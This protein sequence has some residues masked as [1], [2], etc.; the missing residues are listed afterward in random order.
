M[1]ISS[2][3]F[4]RPLTHALGAGLLSIAVGASVVPVTHADPAQ[5]SEASSATNAA[6]SEK[7]I[8][9]LLNAPIPQD[10]DGLLSH[11]KQIS[12]VAG[13]TNEE[14][15]QISE[16]LK[17]ADK[18]VKAARNAQ[19]SS[20]RKAAA[21]QK[22]LAASR[23]NVADIAQAKY[24]GATI[25]PV[26]AV[27]GAS[28]PQAA[29]ERSSYMNSLQD[30]NIRY[31]DTLD[32]DLQEAASANSDANISKFKADYRVNYLTARQTELDERTTQLDRLSGEIMHIVDGFSPA[33]RKRWVDSN[34]PINVDVKAFLA[35]LEKKADGA[36]TGDNDKAGNYAGA[37]AAA[38]SKIG[39]PYGWG[40][41]GPDV[42]DCSGL[43][44]WAYQQIGVSIPRTSS[45]QIAGGTP[46][47]LDALQP[48]DIIGYYPGITHVGMY[49]GDG[50]VVHA[51]D[52]GIPVQVVP[53]NSMPI[54]G[55]ARY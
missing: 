51:A 29:M 21:A 25:D 28:G 41:A 30:K 27:A 48:G 38:M 39:A 3:R 17:N 9:D 49:I 35:G 52:Y 36:S 44:Y 10:F 55:A 14:V 6:P 11:M 26:S 34:G 8:E 16:E 12:R 5:S 40:A 46:V 22:K 1:S 47:S 13:A 53:L 42:F 7:E 45:A 19:E 32:Q 31:L 43:M 18:D 4:R 23:V 15:V 33:D 50:K 37:V 54:S 24:R 20:K 2:L